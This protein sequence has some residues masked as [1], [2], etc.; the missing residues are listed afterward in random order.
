MYALIGCHGVN[1][2]LRSRRPKQPTL[3]LSRC[4]QKRLETLIRGISMPWKSTALVDTLIETAREPA[5]EGLIKGVPINVVGLLVEATGDKS[6]L[7]HK[8]IMGSQN[9]CRVEVEEKAII[10][11]TRWLYRGNFGFVFQCVYRFKVFPQN[12]IYRRVW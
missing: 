3:V 8:R 9:S 10:L 1:A 4:T 11:F 2:L 7:G 6:E 12:G 5:R